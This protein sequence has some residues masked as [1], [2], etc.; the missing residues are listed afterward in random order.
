[1]E[2]ADAKRGWLATDRI[3]AP[4]A[5]AGAFVC[6]GVSVVATR[7]AVAHVDPISLAFLRNGIGFLLL[8]PI[9]RYSTSGAKPIAPKDLVYMTF[10]G[11]SSFAAFPLLFTAALRFAPASHGALAFPAAAPL[12]TLLLAAALG[13]ERW[14]WTKL[15]GIVLSAFGIASALVDSSLSNHMAT[16]TAWLGDILMVFAA[17]T[18]AAYNV[19]SRPFLDRYGTLRL[20][21]VAIGVG[22]GALALLMIWRV[23]IGEFYWRELNATELNAIL[24]VGLASA[25][26]NW[27]W[28]W[29]LSRISPTRVAVFSALNP[30]VAMFGAVVFLGESFT[31]ALAFGLAMVI[32]GILVVNWRKVE[33]G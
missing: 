33:K 1:M 31:V 2:R 20:L 26:S 6:V 25:L 22:A 23:L 7:V 15:G 32:S 14:S 28:S 19:L 24:V 18:V 27:L 9:L 21:S 4:A 29:S 8:F 5:A 3:L 17:A 10:L 13:R 12:L 16:D 11:L 30:L